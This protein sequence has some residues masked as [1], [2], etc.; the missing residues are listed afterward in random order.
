ME[1]KFVSGWEDSDMRA[2]VLIFVG[3]LK[4]FEFENLF[5]VGFMCSLFLWLAIK[6]L[7]N[8]CYASGP[9]YTFKTAD[10]RLYRDT[11]VRN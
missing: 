3:V 11:L 1:D 7:I 9:M 10:S 2:K 5:F 6:F 8:C 4:P